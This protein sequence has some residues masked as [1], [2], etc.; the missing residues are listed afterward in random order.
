LASSTCNA[1]GVCDSLGYCDCNTPLLTG[2]NCQLCITDFYNWPSCTF[3]KRADTCNDLGD[4]TVTASCDCDTGVTGTTC[5][6]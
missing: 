4:C 2:S 3:C 6:L 1:Q 5:E